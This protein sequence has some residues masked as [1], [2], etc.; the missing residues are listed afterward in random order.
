MKKIIKFLAAFILVVILC[1][2]V[3]TWIPLPRDALKVYEQ[4]SETILIKDRHGYLLRE[5]PL[6]GGLKTRWVKLNE[7]SPHLIDA[8][9]CTEDKR[10][11]SHPGFDTIAI[12]RA[13]IQN[14]MAQKVVSGASTI[15]QQVVRNIY[16]LDRNYH[17]KIIE[18]W[19]AARLEHTLSKR[20]ILELYLNIAPY[21]N[22][23]MGVEAASQLYL[24][25]PAMHLSISESAF[26]AAIPQSPSNLNPYLGKDILITRKNYI[27][28]EIL[29][30]KAISKADYDSAIS[31]PIALYTDKSPF[32][33]GHF[34][35][36]VI[37]KLPDNMRIQ[38]GEV[39]TTLDL[40]LQIQ[41]QKLLKNKIEALKKDNVTNGSVIVLDNR[42]GDV[43]VMVGSVDYFLPKVGQVN[44]AISLR[45]P[46]S[47]IKP[48]TYGLAFEK[49]YTP[50]TLFADIETHIS[51]SKWDYTPANYDNLYHGPVL[52]RTSL[53]SSYNIPAVI[54]LEYVG[55]AALLDRLHD[56]GIKSLDK[57]PTH[58]GPGL[59]LGNGEVTLLEMTRAYRAI[60]NG[61]MYSNERLFIN[62]PVAELK[63]VF[64]PD[65]AYLIT[66]ILSDPVARSPAFGRNGPLELPFA[67]A[68]KTGTTSDFRDNWVIGYSRDYTVGVWVG[69]FDGYPMRGVSGITGA[70]PLFKDIFMELYKDKEY[71]PPFE[72][73]QNIISK[74]VCSISGDLPNKYCK[75]RKMEI[76]IYGKDPKNLCS[77]HRG[78]LL[79][80]RNGLLAGA[81]TPAENIEEKTYEIYPPIFLEWA[82][83]QDIAVPPT[84]ISSVGGHNTLLITFPKNGDIFRIDPA[85]PAQAQ[86]IPLKAVVPHE[87]N[88]I[89]WKVDG[90]VVAVSISPFI[91]Q[92]PLNVGNHVIEIE[93]QSGG[94][95]VRG[96]AVQIDILSL[97][98][99]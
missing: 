50:S 34:T 13:F 6:T 26:L 21:G 74:E 87:I 71:P 43:L 15:T 40:P 67:V 92:M 64:P 28:H 45:Q 38:G 37:T 39:I 31:E 3:T 57:E 30:T 56:L 2:Y 62:Q 84:Q 8:T 58:Y 96:K 19:Y 79:D 77:I 55:I 4:K 75:S 44:G 83:R 32:K 80:K 86:A 65:V 59:T 70:G 95:V 66:D 42:T 69:N 93:A 97:K 29:K 7:I 78:Y 14:M 99:E 72:R 10:F 60:A 82:E 68:A 17:N 88:K 54:T 22:Q 52:L 48:F 61:G 16:H 9:I 76:F 33:A 11:F 41:V 47:S 85:I 18:I 63:Y 91:T 89:T 53:A 20:E 90:K 23:I 73:P 12:V 46:G 51:E 24:Q 36:W 98:D 94:K 27:L 35:D 25:K 81:D 1:L 5:V 49:G